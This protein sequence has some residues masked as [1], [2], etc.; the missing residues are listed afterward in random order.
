MGKDVA[1][2]DDPQQSGEYWQSIKEF[3]EVSV[4]FKTQCFPPKL[5]KGTLWNK[6]NRFQ[7]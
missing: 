5:L 3:N 6:E 2:G 7:F 1:A 4:K